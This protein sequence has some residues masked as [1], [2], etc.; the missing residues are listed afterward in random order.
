MVTTCD[1]VPL[2]VEPFGVSPSDTLPPRLI[3]KLVAEPNGT[4]APNLP[5]PNGDAPTDNAGRSTP[6]KQLPT[7]S[8]HENIKARCLISLSIAVDEVIQNQDMFT[9]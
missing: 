7:K 8:L 4:S 9:V 1:P 6:R 5:T 3:D 2:K